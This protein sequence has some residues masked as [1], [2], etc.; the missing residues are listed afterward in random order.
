MRSHNPARAGET[1]PA[2][3]QRPAW[4]KPG[5]FPVVLTGP[6]PVCA[7]CGQP[8]ADKPEHLTQLDAGHYA[9]KTHPRVKFRGWLDSLH[10]QFLLATN[11]AR[12]QGFAVLADYLST[13]AAYCREIMSAE[14]ND[15][16]VA[17]LVV[18]GLNEDEIHAR[19]H[20]PERYF[21]IPHIVPGPD[22]AEILLWLNYLR[23]QT[24][25]IEIRALE[26]FGE[27]RGNLAHA[28]NRLSSAVYMLE[29]MVKAGSLKH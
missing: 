27:T 7:V 18:A 2:S 6:V 28:L 25:E 21:G 1:N 13:L 29:L 4:D 22:D 14:Y 16:A 3:E 10:A 24:R 23:A 5:E 20:Q 8:I 12:R 17:P 9:P 11:L 15:R 19:S 26:T